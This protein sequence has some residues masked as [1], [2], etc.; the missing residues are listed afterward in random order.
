MK[1][2]DISVA[3]SYTT[4][5]PIS[6]PVTASGPNGGIN[7][8][9]SGPSWVSFNFDSSSLIGNLTG[10]PEKAGTYSITFTAT[11]NKKLKSDPKTITINVVDPPGEA[12]GSGGE[13]PTITNPGDKNLIEGQA[14]SFNIPASVKAG[15]L[16]WS[17]TGVPGG[18]GDYG[19][20]INDKTGI[21]SGTPQRIAKAYGMAVNTFQI[22]A[23]VTTNA[24][25]AESEKVKFNLTFVNKN[26]A[27]TLSLVPDEYIDDGKSFSLNLTQG[28][29]S[30]GNP[31]VYIFK[32]VDIPTVAFAD[33]DIP[34]PF[35][36]SYEEKEYVTDTDS[37]NPAFDSAG[38]AYN[39]NPDDPADYF[40]SD[41]IPSGIGGA[42]EEE[43]EYNGYARLN[44]ITKPLKGPYYS[45]NKP[46]LKNK[47]KSVTIRSQYAAGDTNDDS[48]KSNELIKNLQSIGINFDNKTGNFSGKTTNFNLK[49]REPLVS[50]PIS[51][52]VSD[53]DFNGDSPVR[54][55]NIKV[56]DTNHQPTIN[57]SGDKTI[58]ENTPFSI[59]LSCSD[60]DGDKLTY[61]FNGLPRSD[62][63][64]FGINFNK[65]T[66][67]LSGTP[68]NI[69][70]HFKKTEN[71][72]IVQAYY[73]DKKSDSNSAFFNIT[74][75]GK[76]SAPILN[77]I[78]SLTVTG[79]QAIDIS[80]QA[81]D[82]DND[83]IT[84]YTTCVPSGLKFDMSTGKFTG[85]LSFTINNEGN[86]DLAKYTIKVYAADNK[87]GYSQLKGFIITLK[88]ANIS[89]DT[90]KIN[91]NK[92][93]TRFKNYIEPTVFNSSGNNPNL[94]YLDGIPIDLFS[95]KI[96]KN[97][98]TANLT[99]K[100]K[101]QENIY[102]DGG[103]FTNS[104][105]ETS[106]LL[107]ENI[108]LVQATPTPTPSC[109]DGIT[110][111]AEI[112]DGT[113]M[114]SSP[115][116][117]SI[118]CTTCS[119]PT[120]T[121]TPTPSCG[122]GVKNGADECD[123]TDSTCAFGCTSTCICMPPTS[124][125]STTTS[126]TTSG[127]TSSTTTSSTTS[128]T[129]TPTPSSN[130]SSTPASSSTSSGY[131]DSS[132]TE[133]SASSSTSSGSSDSSSTE[134]SAPA[135]NNTMAGTSTS[136]TGGSSSMS[137]TETQAQCK[138]PTSNSD[139]Y[140][141]ENSNTSSPTDGGG[142]S[143][144]AGGGGPSIPFGGV[145]SVPSAGFG[146]GTSSNQPA[147]LPSNSSAYCGDGTTNGQEECDGYDTGMCTSCNTTTC[148]CENSAPSYPASGPSTF[149][150]PSFPAGGPSTFGAPS[151][152]A[153]DPSTFGAPSSPTGGPS[154]YFREIDNNKAQVAGEQ[155]PCKTCIDKYSDKS[156]CIK[157]SACTTECKMQ[158]CNACCP[159][160]K[161]SAENRLILYVDGANVDKGNTA[162]NAALNKITAWANLAGIDYATLNNFDFNTNSN[163]TGD[164]DRKS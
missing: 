67:E 139:Y 97:I 85:N 38:A 153:S 136:T 63:K 118:D 88:K 1:I 62:T 138:F 124:T 30:D 121:P 43:L 98:L 69:T 127:T 95:G 2:K 29:D 110:N 41:Y 61:R 99:S 134:D 16:T 149:G 143:Q 56:Q 83:P 47:N 23:W 7:V 53:G 123:G 80:L 126:S 14:F 27:P 146:M 115:D 79:N 52:Y 60:L 75:K 132:S 87:G 151:F 94:I 156:D 92:I 73:T 48:Q 6:I 12:E 152:P 40:I 70:E 120:P 86:I 96:N 22:T 35:Q 155:N 45:K 105:N 26:K 32:S 31:L 19:I 21:V 39:I 58:N 150:A 24:G 109:G 89:F 42:C 71:N 147:P 129:V 4:N 137:N 25:S 163:C 154:F 130:P 74:I 46:Q 144:P 117:C 125:S 11:D 104:A 76:N 37:G 15:S 84:Y 72:F 65:D 3:S 55:F 64:D 108:V 93:V 113:D 18:G 148:M 5:Q 90:P 133:D 157:C 34:G 77:S 131:A 91:R 9:A 33:D 161:L 101:S 13:P 49:Y 107:K 122:D 28:V 59:K 17:I 81:M 100:T 114:C 8:T 54:T 116:T 102:I 128:G 82:A 159:D 51:V 68:I 66:G 162:A 160:L 57:N 140:G 112:C 44:K 78:P 36:Y 20:T 103:Y 135:E 142:S 50:I 145:P 111:G 119:T 158:D 106:H 141:N 10:K 164:G